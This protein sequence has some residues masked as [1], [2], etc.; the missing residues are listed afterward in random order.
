MKKLFCILVFVFPFVAF[1]QN[2]QPA[3]NSM[4]SVRN[5]MGI[6]KR[7]TTGIHHEKYSGQFFKPQTPNKGSLIQIFDSV[8]LWQLDTSNN[9]WNI[10]LRTIKMAYDAHNNLTSCITQSWNGSAWVNYY[11]YTYTYDANNNQIGK[12]YQEWNDNAWVNY[13]QYTYTYDANNNQTSEI[14]QSW[15]NS[16][17][18]NL[19]QYIYTY[20]AGNKVTNG[21]SQTWNGSAWVNY[22][23]YTYTY[24]ANNNQT[25]ELDQSWSNSTW[26]NMWQN[27]NYY[28][29]SNKL[30]NSLWQR[31]NDSSWWNYTL[32]TYTYDTNTNLTSESEQSWN[33][34]AWW[35]YY[36]YTYTYDAS[37][38]QTSEL[39]QFWWDNAWA[40][41]WEQFSS[42]DANNFTKSIVN[43]NWDITGTEVTGSDSTYYYF[44]T[45]LGINDL[46]LQDTGITIYPNPAS[47]QITVLAPATQAK[48][49]LSIINLN[50][51]EVLT[52]QI[53][54]PKTQIDISTLPVGV[55]FIR[56]ANDKT[57]EVGRFVKEYKLKPF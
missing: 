11:Q 42:Y 57:V 48:N 22:I 10:Y 34:S 39:S 30:T 21:L 54:Q 3:A 43:I 37:N 17:W 41:S 31:W 53:I 23:Q 4:E 28:N 9:E 24:D 33:G 35:N 36:Q 44:H 7:T 40:N 49:Q 55:Y 1:A 38:K 19:N 2:Q 20:N 46:K 47:D 8:Y 15:S 12:L 13:Y 18:V 27:T 25:M 16:T 50:G 56:V 14:D 6:T 29:V 5:M 52:C 32:S 26:V 51:Q 45:V